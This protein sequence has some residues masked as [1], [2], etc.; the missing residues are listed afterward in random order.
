MNN[1]RKMKK[2]K[3]IN[4]QHTLLAQTQGLKSGRWKIIYQAS[5]NGKKRETTFTS[6]KQILI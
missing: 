3:R 1:K 4:T 6:E 5:G 2:K